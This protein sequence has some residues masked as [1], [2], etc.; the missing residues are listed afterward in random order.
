MLA[1]APLPT[2]PVDDLDM[3]AKEQLM[4]NEQSL[5]GDYGEA[6]GGARTMGGGAVDFF[7]S[8]GTERQ[9]KAKVDKPNPDNVSFEIL[10]LS[11]A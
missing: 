10:S 5:T 8:L 7:S 11:G 2:V 4:L 3:Q 9:K 1:P 6:S